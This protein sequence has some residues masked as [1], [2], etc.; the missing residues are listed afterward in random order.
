M[1]TIIISATVALLILIGVSSDLFLPKDNAVE[2]TCE[3][4]IK[5][6]TGKDIELSN[7]ELKNSGNGMSEQNAQDLQK[8]QS[9]Q[10]ETT[11]KEPIKALSMSLYKKYGV[12]IARHDDENCNGPSVRDAGA[13]ANYYDSLRDGSSSSSRSECDCDNGRS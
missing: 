3:E 6:L 5:D 2:E 4:G 1:I 12:I 8:N 11:T 7:W 10:N 9:Q 13:S